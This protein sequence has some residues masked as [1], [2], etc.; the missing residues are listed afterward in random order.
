MAKTPMVVIVNRIMDITNDSLH[1]RGYCYVCEC[2]DRFR[3]LYGFGVAKDFILGIWKWHEL[4]IMLLNEGTR[5]AVF[6]G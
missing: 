6:S 4:K 2:Q 3:E 5:A 1:D